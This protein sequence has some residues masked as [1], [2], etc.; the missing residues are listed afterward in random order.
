MCTKIIPGILRTVFHAQHN[1]QW[2]YASLS[3]YTV[4]KKKG[5]YKELELC[6]PRKKKNQPHIFPQN[7]KSLMKIIQWNHHPEA[8]EIR[9]M[10]SIIFLWSWSEPHLFQVNCMLFVMAVIVLHQLQAFFSQTHSTCILMINVIFNLSGQH[11]K[12][13][14][15]LRLSTCS[16][17]PACRHPI[18]PIEQR[19]QWAQVYPGD[20]NNPANL[21]LILMNIYIHT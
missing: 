20:I 14:N 18:E 19:S 2:K 16:S 10:I 8:A 15:P 7:R 13:Y 21:L 1:L 17:G 6:F 5:L 11:S 4:H 3:T 12:L 9:F